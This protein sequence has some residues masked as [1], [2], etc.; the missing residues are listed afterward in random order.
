VPNRNMLFATIAGGI[1]EM[2]EIHLVAFGAQMDD[3]VYPDNN[4]GFTES[5]DETFKYSLNQK[6]V[7]NF[8]SPLVH[9][10]KH[11]VL[12][13]G[14]KLGVPFEYVTSCY[15]PKL[16]KGKI[17]NCGKCGCDAYRMNAFKM[18]KV[19]DPQKTMGL[20]GSYWEGCE[21]WGNVR[22]R[23]DHLRDFKEYLVL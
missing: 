1:A 14:L 5:I 12:E 17:V 11:E 7:V 8:R 9:L 13:L 16:I 15:Y 6:T 23:I 21:V 20:D 10:I 4:I 22:S 19:R 18:M 3:A 2:K